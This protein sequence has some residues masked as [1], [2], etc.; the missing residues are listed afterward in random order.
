MPKGKEPPEHLEDLVVGVEVF[1]NCRHLRPHEAKPLLLRVPLRLDHLALGLEKQ[2]QRN[3]IQSSHQVPSQPPSSNAYMP[4]L[5][6]KGA[7]SSA[8]KEL[9]VAMPS[10]R[11]MSSAEMRR[12]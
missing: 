11:F 7:L 8:R 6:F 2:G 12:I 9:G 3:S 4:P 10:P 5:E 1:K